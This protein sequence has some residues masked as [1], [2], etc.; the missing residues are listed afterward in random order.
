MTTRPP[1]REGYR[2]YVEPD[3]QLRT[4]I[5]NKYG[6]W[7]AF[8]TEVIESSGEALDKCA[9]HVDLKRIVVEVP[10]KFEGEG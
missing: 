6:M 8:L 9:E 2:W 1:A 4:R 7:G 5:A 3:D 10:N